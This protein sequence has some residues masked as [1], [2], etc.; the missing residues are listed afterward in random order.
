MTSSALFSTMTSRLRPEMFILGKGRMSWSMW[1]YLRSSVGGTTSRQ[2]VRMLFSKT[3]KWDPKYTPSVMQEVE[4]YWKPIIKEQ[5]L[6]RTKIQAEKKTDEKPKYYVLSMFPYPSGKLH[7]GH[8]RVYAISDTMARFHRMMGKEV[9]HP[10][11]WDAFGLPAENAA[12]ER[13]I[14]PEVWTKSNIANMKK[15]LDDLGCSF[16]WDRE[17]TT[18][19]PSY[20]KWTQYLFLEMYKAGLVYQKEAE[21]N[22]DPVDQT[23]LADEQI[24][25]D[26]LSWRSGA[27]VEKRFLRQWFIKTTAYSKSLL[28]GLN[29]VSPELWRDVIQLQKNWIRECNGSRFDFK[30]Q[31]N[32][33]YTNDPISVFTPNPE[34]L[35]GVSHIALSPTH[36]YNDPKFYKNTEKSSD[37]VLS[38]EAV[39]PFT[40]QRIPLVVSSSTE[41]D[42]FNDTHLGIPCLSEADRSVAE[43]LGF[44]CVD[45]ITE[46]KDGVEVACNSDE[47]SGLSRSDAFTAVMAHAK[48]L[49]VGGHLVSSRLKDWLISRQRFWGTPIPMIHCP[50]CKTVPVPTDHL[51]VTLPETDNQSSSSRISPLA[52]NDDWINVKCP[53]CGGSARRETDTMDTF[54]DSSWYFLRYTDPH[55]TVAPFDSKLAKK[56][57]PVDLYIGG[58]EHAVLHLYFARFFN[59]FLHD[60]DLVPEREPFVNLLTQGMVMGQS[61]RVKG[62]GKYLRAEDVDFSGSKSTEKVSGSPVVTDWEKMSKSKYNGVDPEDVISEFGV[63]ST[64][65][66][67]LSGVAP[68]TNRKWSN[69][70]FRG[71]QNWQNKVWKLVTEYMNSVS[72]RTNRNEMPSPELVAEWNSKISNQR[73][74]CVREVSFHFGTTFLLSVG[75]SRMQSF[76]S[77]LKKVPPAVLSESLEFERA[78][79]DLILMV[80][81]V[82]PHFTSE[83]W[84]GLGSTVIH[85]KD[86]YQWNKSVLE[87][88][89]PVVDDSFKL[90][91]VIMSNGQPM[92]EYYLPWQ[93]LKVLT[94]KEACEIAKQDSLYQKYCAP[95]TIHDVTFTSGTGYNVSIDFISS[96]AKMRIKEDSENMEATKLEDETKTK[97]VHL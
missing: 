67:I 80:A 79:A 18:C 14:R 46:N 11:G 10:M 95:H 25:E 27:K 8:V 9:L 70:A 12:I 34:A 93:K 48:K 60:R 26:G 78:L 50:S 91:L 56:Y 24:S 38:L 40:G 53:K 66:C 54:V 58:K 77:S 92:S 76:T 81:P 42:E 88:T 47:F 96:E 7:M 65:L 51:P 43:K 32:G 6:E 33:N 55:N 71:I 39:H 4:G 87:Q 85:T 19:D 74:L 52:N 21:V 22:W 36:R 63:D 90:P 82:A 31:N 28:D 17:V 69:E 35:Y 73:N 30:I 68:K 5:N 20:Y 94:F 2:A 49:G 86:M 61:F 83:L 41:F 84:A 15:Q 29:N 57:M 62:T 72:S 1:Q 13:G 3:G 23:V 45:V 37:I 97:S 59:H 44:P 16:D 64:R 75:I 89:W